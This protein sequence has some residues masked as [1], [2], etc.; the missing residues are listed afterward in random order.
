VNCAVEPA[1][2]VAFGPMSLTKER[3]E[4]LGETMKV[5]SAFERFPD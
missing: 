2:S 3:T 4:L 5:Q 1:R